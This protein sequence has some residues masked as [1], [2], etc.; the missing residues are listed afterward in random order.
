MTRSLHRDS[1]ARALFVVVA[2][3]YL[4]VALLTAVR[5]TASTSSTPVKVTAGKP[6]E[7]R[8]T[9]V[10]LI[11]RLP[12]V[13]RFT[14]TNVG[15]RPHQFKV[16]TT[17]VKTAALHTCVGKT[18]SLLKKG[19]SAT[20]VVSFAKAGRFEYLSTPADAARG[21]KGLLT[22]KARVPLPVTTTPAVTT[23]ITTVSV[24]TTSTTTPTTTGSASTA[25][26]SVVWTNVGCGGC[27]VLASLKGAVNSSLNST[28][29]EPFKGGALTQQQISDV[30]AYINAS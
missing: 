26:G 29:P 28:H 8:F 13:V 21:M 11:V 27:H 17:P 5:A 19:K 4:L 30:S 23:P 22:V 14:V 2:L 15:A 18:T 3:A 7:Y 12:G 25:A 9:V 6:S 20:L 1:T 24:T 10:P 16:C